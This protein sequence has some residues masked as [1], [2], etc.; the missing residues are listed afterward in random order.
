MKFTI[1]YENKNQIL[2]GLTYMGY[3]ITTNEGN[4]GVF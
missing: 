4:N 3:K 2:S 1:I